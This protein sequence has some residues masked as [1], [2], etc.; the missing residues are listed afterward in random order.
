[1]Q[2]LLRQKND[3]HATYLRCP[4]SVNLRNTWRAMRS[5]SQRTL[6][7]MR[8]RWWCSFAAEMQGYADMND[9]YNFYNS[10]KLVTGPEH[11]NLAIVKDSQGNI[12][13]DRAIVINRWKGYFSDVLNRSNHPD[14]DI[15]G[16]LPSQETIECMDEVPCRDEVAHA[17]SRLSTLK[18]NKSPGLDSL[19]AELLK[20]GGERLAAMLHELIALI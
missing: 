2:A 8:N 16:R 12:L 9:Q 4:T 17:V 5:D 19:P 14:P 15:L 3:A 13:R 7:Q 6:S 1:M 18:N 10:M 11:N 20:Y